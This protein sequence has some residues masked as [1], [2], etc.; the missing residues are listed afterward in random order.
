M[1]RGKLVADKRAGG[2]MGLDS[3]GFANRDAYL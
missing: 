3:L 1:D 2:A